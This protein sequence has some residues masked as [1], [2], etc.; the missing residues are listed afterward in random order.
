MP[1]KEFIK[2][3]VGKHADYYVAQFEEIRN[4]GKGKINWAAF[5]FGLP[6]AAYRGVMD[7]WLRYIRFSLLF[8]MEQAI[9]AVI[10]HFCRMYEYNYY[11]SKLSIFF[12]I[13][14]LICQ[15]RFARNFNQVYKNH[16]QR[17]IFRK[18][19][20]PD[21]SVKRAVKYSLL[22][23]LFLI[24]VTSI[25]QVFIELS[26]EAYVYQFWKEYTHISYMDDCYKWAIH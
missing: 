13:A 10:F 9:I 20:R 18:D 15:F 12:S 25:T 24:T 19:S 23:L 5:F 8:P 11:L 16:V 22:F 21:P 2:A 6:H 3:I 1:T 26:R 17:K 14:Y 7:K 4:G